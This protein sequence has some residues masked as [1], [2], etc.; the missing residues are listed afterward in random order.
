MPKKKN[1]SQIGK[2]VPYTIASVVKFVS[3]RYYIPLSR[4]S[5]RRALAALPHIGGEC[6]VVQADGKNI[7]GVLPLSKKE[8]DLRRGLESIIGCDVL[9]GDVELLEGVPVSEV[10]KV[11]VDHT[12]LKGLRSWISVNSNQE[13][14]GLMAS[15]RDG[16]WK[17][18]KACGLKPEVDR[19]GKDRFRSPFFLM[20]KLQS[21][22]LKKLLGR[23]I[24]YLLHKI[25]VDGIVEP[26]C[27]AD[28]ALNIV[29][30]ECCS[31]DWKAIVDG[32]VGLLGGVE[33]WMEGACDEIVGGLVLYRL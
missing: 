27:H 12:D 26:G 6:I 3:E 5:G 23:P 8:S 33:G 1:K 19:N 20:K 10:F 21:A 7:L 4:L 13:V 32:L 29:L 25:E 28:A 15:D 18:W 16:F 24:E 14:R 31:F 17:M 22:R 9:V 11:V 30:Q 2:I